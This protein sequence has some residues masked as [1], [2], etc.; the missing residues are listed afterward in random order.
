M[1][2]GYVA[3]TFAFR[4]GREGMGK[5]ERDELHKVTFRGKNSKIYGHQLIDRAPRRINCRIGRRNTNQPTQ[6]KK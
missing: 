6:E 1:K 2:S 3:V 5:G 4:R